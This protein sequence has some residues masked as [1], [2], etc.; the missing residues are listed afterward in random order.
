[1]FR[2]N[3]GLIGSR[4]TPTIPAASGVWSLVEQILAART[5]SWPGQ[6]PIPTLSP[7]LWY[8]FSDESTVTLSSTQITAVADKGSRGWNLSKSTT[9]PSY[10]TGINGLKCCDWGSPGHGNYLRN[11][12][13]TST[14]IAEIY[15]VL[16]GNFGS[17]FVEYYGLATGTTGS[18][19]YIT[20]D[21]A[22]RAGLINLNSIDQAFLNNGA[23]NQIASVLPTINSPALMRVRK[24]DGTTFNT[25]VGFQ[26]G[27]Q[28]TDTNRG[29]GG[30]IGEVVAFSTLL[31]ESDR[32]LLQSFLARK[33]GLTL[34]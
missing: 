7:L 6:N 14:N 17:T 2:T 30:L 28:R 9:G 20:G 11:T 10:V 8:D 3:G 22:G 31:S 21:G 23:S 26:L 24:T 34:A 15:F 12:S 18:S 13:A 32:T 1:M 29:W 25:T 33:W 4:R 19:W 5:N 27:Q 16:D